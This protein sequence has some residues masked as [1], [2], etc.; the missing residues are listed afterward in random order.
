MVFAFYSILAFV[1][2]WVIFEILPKKYQFFAPIIA[3]IWAIAIYF[4]LQLI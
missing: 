4:L 3:F 1:L 2:S